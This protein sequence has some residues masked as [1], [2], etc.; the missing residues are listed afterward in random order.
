[1]FEYDPDLAQQILGEVFRLLRM[2]AITPVQPL[3]VFPLSKIESAFRLIQSGKHLGKV[4]LKAE[5]DTEVKVFVLHLFGVLLSAEQRN[6]GSAETSRRRN[7]CRRRFLPDRRWAG[8]FGPR[9][10]QLDGAQEVQEHCPYLPLRHEKFRRPKLG[11]RARDI[12]R[13]AKSLRLRRQQCRR[14]RTYL[15]SLLQGDASNPGRDTISHG[16]QSES[17]WTQLLEN[18]FA[19]YEKDSL[20]NKMTLADYEDALRPKVRGTLNL[21]QQLSPTTLDFFILLSSCAGIIG[22][23]GQANYASAC[24]FQDAFARHCTRLGMLTRSLDLGMIDG[25]GYVSQNLDSL[26]FLTAQGFQAVKLPEF[27]ALLDYAITEPIHSVDDSQLVIGLTGPEQGHLPPN[28]LDAK[29]TYLRASATAHTTTALPSLQSSI[30]NARSSAEAQHLITAA[31]ISQV[32]KVL[33]VPAED[34]DPSKSISAYGGDSLTAVELRNWFSK[35]LNASIGVMEILSRKSLE[36][37]AQETVGRSRLVALAIEG[38][39]V[40]DSEEAA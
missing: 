26:R 7:I 28:L 5:A 35:T 23:N 22:N 21:H 18:S 14:A 33:V 11:G 39:S 1:M 8:R 40:G 12:R 36:A 9:N 24:T 31:I 3:N 10:V 29:F 37:L 20:I 27:F 2:G 30:Q 4:V 32:S 38:A 34:I 6:T 19:D 13:K 25:A 17:H 15:E 16:H